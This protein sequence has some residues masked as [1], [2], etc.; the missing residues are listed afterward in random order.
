ME[1]VEKKPLMKLEKTG[2]FLNK[3]VNLLILNNKISSAQYKEFGSIYRIYI[4]IEL[5]I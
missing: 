3:V 4:Y 1:M 5:T 2:L